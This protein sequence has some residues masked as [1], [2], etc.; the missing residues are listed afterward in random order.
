MRPMRRTAPTLFMLAAI[1]LPISASGAVAAEADHQISY[2][3]QPDRLAIFLNG[4]AYAVD[5]VT[6]PGGVHDRRTAPIDVI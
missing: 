4:V 1:A 2:T 6:L 5:E 3:S